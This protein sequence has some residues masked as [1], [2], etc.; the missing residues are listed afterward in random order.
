[1]DETSRPLFTHLLTITDPRR[2][3]S[4]DHPL[5][6]ILFIAGCAIIC[7]VDG[8]TGVAGWEEAKKTW[9]STFLDLPFGIPGHD[10]F[11]R[12][13]SILNPEQFATAFLTWMTSTSSS[14][15]RPPRLASRSSATWPDGMTPTSSK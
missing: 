12:V 11:R 8:W 2:D 4:T 10:T 13:F 5:K 14:R 7:G 15:R 6:S 3:A 9:L 1:M